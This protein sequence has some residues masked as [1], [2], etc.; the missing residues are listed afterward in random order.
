[1]KRRTFVQCGLAATLG[2]P[3]FA[4]LR[5]ERLDEAAD[6]LKFYQN[7]LLVGS[8]ALIGGQG[9]GRSVS[10]LPPVLFV[11]L[12]RENLL[13]D[14]GNVWS[15]FGETRGEGVPAYIH[16]ITGPSRSADIEGDLSIGVH[17]PYR[18]SVYLLE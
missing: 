4:A 2:T 10:L 11:V 16:W 12:N 9:R 15:R 3:L 14:T 8:I 17:G 13:S 7:G 6:V 1:M 5:Q 18:V